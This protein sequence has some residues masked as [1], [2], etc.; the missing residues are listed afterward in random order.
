MI[1]DDFYGSPDPQKK[2]KLYVQSIL[3]HC[4]EDPEFL[5]LLMSALQSAHTTAK[6]VAVR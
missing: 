1:E 6:K 3:D 4:K 5:A 2:N